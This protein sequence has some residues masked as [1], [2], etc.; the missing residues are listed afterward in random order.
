M[1]RITRILDVQYPII[2]GAMRL[3]TLGEMAAAVSNSGGFGQIASSSL[4][5]ERLGDEIEKA[6]QLTDRPFG[7]N[8]PLHRPPAS[9]FLEIAAA[10]GIRVITTSGGNPA[11]IMPRA[12]EL[13]L[14]VFHKVSTTAMG[15]KAQDAGVSAVIATGFEAGGH[16]GKEQ[17]TTFCL[18]P[19]LADILEIPVI[20]AG[21]IS[22]GRT[23]CAAFALGAEGVEI[24]TRFLASTEC[25]A[26]DYYKKAI[27]GAQ[28]N[29]TTC[30][31]HGKMTIR[32]LRNPA[33]EA[34]ADPD[35][36]GKTPVHAADYTDPGADADTC[37]MPA[38]MGAGMIRK[39][40]PARQIIKEM[41]ARARQSARELNALFGK[42][43]GR[44]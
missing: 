39:T 20:A 43:E 15:L 5:P 36:G 10:K 18:V 34:L 33:A 24:G 37:I 31:G 23:L 30:L 32:V 19:Q 21:G 22:D 1:T 2:L 25:P 7:I 14:A 13:G 29:G 28:D 27:A 11:K 41:T 38:G 26:A 9:E 42:K 17:L 44:D 12:R 8:I 35:A 4:T 6:R 3:L 16:G 40:V